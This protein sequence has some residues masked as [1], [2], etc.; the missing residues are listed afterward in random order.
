MY[1][2]YEELRWR[3][4]EALERCNKILEEKEEL[5]ARTQ[6]KSVRFDQE[7]VEGTP[8]AHIFDDYVMTMEKRKVN[9]RLAEARSILD[10]RKHLL[11]H[12]EWELRQSKDIKDRLFVLRYLDRW[13]IRRI[14]KATQYSEAQIYRLLQEIRESLER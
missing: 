3:Y 2:E 7:R 1:L 9:E 14:S 12:K 6:P 11:E 8:N 5:F 4:N 10:E 13:R